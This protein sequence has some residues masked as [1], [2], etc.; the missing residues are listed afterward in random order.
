MDRVEDLFEDLGDSEVVVAGCFGVLVVETTA[1][2]FLA[3]VKRVTDGLVEDDGVRSLHER[4]LEG[5]GA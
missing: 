4:A 2:A 3:E 5:G 1:R